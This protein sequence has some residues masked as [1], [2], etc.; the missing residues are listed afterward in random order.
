MDL[1]GKAIVITGGAQG[2]G[3]AMAT[4]L[5]SKTS[6][7][8]LINRNEDVLAVTQALCEQTGATVSG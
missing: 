4:R 8:A 2:L 3:C 6:H 1:T 5:A 7:L